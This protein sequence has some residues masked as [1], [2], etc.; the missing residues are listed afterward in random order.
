LA[1]LLGGLQDFKKQKYFF[2]L[3]M[4]KIVRKV[5]QKLKIKK[6]FQNETKKNFL[7]MKKNFQKQKVHQH[8]EFFKKCCPIEKV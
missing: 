5:F 4:K 1:E 7:M 6:T 2:A 3:K 8:M